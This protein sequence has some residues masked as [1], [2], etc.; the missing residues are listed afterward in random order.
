M[1]TPGV[2]DIHPSAHVSPDAVARRGR[3]RRTRRGR[4]GRRQDRRRHDDHGQ[5]RRHGLRDDRPQLQDPPRRVRRRRPAGP[6]V[7]GRGHAR[8]DRRRH[9]H[10]RVRDDPPRD[11]ARVGATIVGTRLLP[12]G[13][14][15]R[16]ARLRDRRPAS[17]VCNCALVAGHVHVGDRAFL[18]GNTVI[19]QFSRIG[20]LAMLGGLSGVGLDV[21][22]YLTVA[23][24]QRGPR[25]QH[26]R[27][28]P[29]RVRPRVPPPRPDRLSRALRGDDPVR[30]ASTRSARLGVERPEIRAIVS[31]FEVPSK[32]GFCRPPYGTR[33]RRLLRGVRRREVRA[34]R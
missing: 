30:R 11:Q 5:R 21:G 4:R 10:P 17:C 32:R 16:R 24:R 27:A 23:R 2:T 8:R 20:T 26:G 12:H 14:L 33:A 29:R 7:R 6:R 1:S 15:A 19:H 34:P 3:A 9:G 22:P 13:Q 18:S 31:F 28:A 25:D